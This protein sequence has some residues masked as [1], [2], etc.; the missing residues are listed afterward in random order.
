MVIWKG[1]L[2]GSRPRL[3]HE[4]PNTIKGLGVWERPIYIYMIKDLLLIHST[5]TIVTRIEHRIYIESIQIHIRKRSLIQPE[6]LRS[7]HQELQVGE[8]HARCCQGPGT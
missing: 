8:G 2:Y 5:A 3:P 4:V 6:M 1:L 7:E